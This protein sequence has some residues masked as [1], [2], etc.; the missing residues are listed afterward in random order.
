MHIDEY[1]FGRMVIDGQSYDSDLIIFPGEVRS[2]WWRDEGHKLKLAD[3]KE[4]LA[5][6]PKLLMVGCGFSGI[7]KVSQEVSDYCASHGI[8]LKAKSSREVVKEY[9]NLTSKEGV[10]AV[11]HLTC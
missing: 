2:S 11:F 6:K 3:L 5:A 9:N 8:E 4:V 10:I 1:D 7:M